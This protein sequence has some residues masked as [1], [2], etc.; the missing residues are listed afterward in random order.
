M[1]D[2]IEKARLFK[3]VNGIDCWY[4]VYEEGKTH[5]LEETN[6]YGTEFQSTRHSNIM[7]IDI[8]S[9][10]KRAEKEGYKRVKLGCWDFIQNKIVQTYI[11]SS[12]DKTTTFITVMGANGEDCGAR[13]VFPYL[14]EEDIKMLHEWTQHKYVGHYYESLEETVQ[15]IKK[16]MELIQEYQRFK[17]KFENK[18]FELEKMAKDLHIV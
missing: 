4:I 14:K 12:K 1:S 11:R 16:H 2:R 6:N 17:K 10:L 7:G 15:E 8:F 5:I 9:I 13:E 3:I 18:E